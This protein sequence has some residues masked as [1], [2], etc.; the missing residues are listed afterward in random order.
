MWIKSSGP[1]TENV[2]Q[3]TT[4]VS[5]HFLIGGEFAAIVDTGVAATQERLISELNKYLGESSEL[6]YILLTHAHFDHVGGIPFLRSYAP[7]VKLACGP[8][9]AQVLEDKNNLK[10]FYEKNKAVAEALKAP[11]E[12]SLE[13]WQAS[14]A[15][16]KV[17]GDGDI[18]D[19]GAEV[20]VKLIGCPGHTEDIVAY[21]VRPDGALAAGEA[22]GSYAG[23]D[24]LT[25]CY[26][27]SYHNYVISLDRLSGLEIKV[28]GLPHS[29]A[30]TG[31]MP[32][33]YLVDARTAA[34]RFAAGI[35]ERLDQ[36][37]LVDEICSS[38]LLE[39]V[40]QNICPEGPF[41]SEQADTLKS[42]VRVIAENR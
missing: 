32:S 18:I 7:G 24:K 8:Q 12:M 23:R 16:D 1:L 19:M 35:K 5:T 13:E 39:W 36:G 9:T 37:E 33:K 4:A 11:F 2:Y 25:P 40:S 21:Y 38:Q 34:E 26:P 28:L 14:F 6:K 27:W 17:L 15:V 42:M 3:L 20:E 41:V 22:V 30:L 10:L 29:G 31:E